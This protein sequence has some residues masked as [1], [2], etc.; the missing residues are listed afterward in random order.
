LVLAS[1]ALLFLGEMSICDQS[2]LPA[3]KLNV[4][5]KRASFLHGQIN[6]RFAA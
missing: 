2:Y 3:S 5:Q 4:I 1:N 6:Q